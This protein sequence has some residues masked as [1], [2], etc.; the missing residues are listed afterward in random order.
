MNNR[1][2][3]I[4]AA[5]QG[6]AGRADDVCQRLLKAWSGGKQA[7]FVPVAAA[8]LQTDSLPPLDAVILVAD[9][10]ATQS[11]TLT[12][13]TA[14]DEACVPVL[15]LL[16]ERPQGENFFEFGGCVITCWDSPPE[17][18][19]DLLL[20]LMHRQQHVK[21][22]REEMSLSQRFHGGLKGQIAKMHEELQLAALVQREFL[23]REAPSMQGVEFAALWRPSNYVSG[24]IYDLVR[25]DEDRVGV[26]IADAV[27][28]GVPA[29]LMT[30]VIC[31]SLTTKDITGNTYRIV[32]PSEVLAR[33]NTE[34]IRRQG[35]TT[36]FATAVYAVVDC[37]RRSVQLAGAGHPPPVLL[38]SD[39]SSEVLE[40]SG[41]LL[42]VFPDEAFNQIEFDLALHDRLLFYTDGF[43]QAFPA[44]SID[45]YE[46]RLP[47]TRYRSEFDQLSRLSTAAEMIDSIS[48]R[49]DDQTGSLHQIDDLTLVCVLAGSL[50]TQRPQS[51]TPGEDGPEHPAASRAQERKGLRLAS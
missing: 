31:R 48:Q 49:I 51:S 33:L 20:G 27:G 16:D 6:H 44:A 37:R 3:V 2:N 28:H 11:T 34:M 46:R 4:V 47:T 14:L 10:N 29:A 25:L 43:E 22:L 17:R 12:L 36:R 18:I 15:A 26:F 35:R 40:T 1:W 23:P 45:S 21:R 19:C 42:G 24:D 38:R 32:P 39:G 7:A 8:E 30:M 5:L 50:V 13:L 41:G 9:R